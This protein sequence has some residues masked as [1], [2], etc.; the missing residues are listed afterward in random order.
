MAQYEIKWTRELWLKVTI[1]AES[2]QQ[3]LSKFWDGEYENPQLY[4]SEIQDDIDIYVKE[5]N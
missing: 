4:G 1:E 3:A 2:E 5:Q